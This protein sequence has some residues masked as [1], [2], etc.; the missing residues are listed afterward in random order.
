MVKLLAKLVAKL[1]VICFYCL[2]ATLLCRTKEGEALNQSRIN[3]FQILYSTGSSETFFSKCGGLEIS[4][5]PLQHNN[6]VLILL[7]LTL[8]PFSSLVT[9]ANMLQDSFRGGEASEDGS[10]PTLLVKSLS[11]KHFRTF[12]LLGLPPDFLSVAFIKP[13]QL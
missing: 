12:Q 7:R 1:A 13:S 8:M 5:G 9:P 3:L 2:L 6:P 4:S 11:R 10:A